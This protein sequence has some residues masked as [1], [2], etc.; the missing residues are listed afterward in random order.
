MM[1]GPFRIE[2]PR[3]RAFEC[4]SAPFLF[5]IF[6]VLACPA[7]QAHAQNTGILTGR[8]T[9]SQGQPQA[10]LVHAF[11]EGDIPAGDAYTD[12]NGYYVIMGL[13]NGTYAVVVEVEGYKPF[14]GSVRLDNII[15]PRGQVMVVLEPAPKEA[16]KMGPMVA[17]SKSSGEVNAQHPLPPFDP[18]AVKEFDKGNKEQ[19]RG[20]TQAALEHYQKALRVDANFYPA[21]NNM[22]TL[23]E[24]QGNHVKAKEVFMKARE[25]N[26]DDGEAYIN[27]GHV[28]YEEGQFRPA[29][30]QLDRG[31]QRS[32]QSAVG[33]FFLGSAYFK[34]REAEKAEP[35]LK[36]ACA[37]DPQ[38]MAP[39]HLQLA[40]LYLQ[41]HDYGAAKVQLQTFLQMNPSAPQAPAIKKMLADLGRQ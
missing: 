7:R 11:A 22:G 19:Q 40:N 28:L 16:A 32:P 15:Q 23:F 34:L 21:L 29:V 8:V 18:K 20:N 26:P 14:R 39:A 33:N 12:S 3:R 13:P 9:N 17:G 35:L 24:Q 27:L 6:L 30:D 36:R 38:H 37:L 25:I 10:V 4:S 1:P 2:S 31:L 41:R 5:A